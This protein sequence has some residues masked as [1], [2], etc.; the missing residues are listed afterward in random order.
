[1]PRNIP[2]GNGDLLMAYVG[3]DGHLHLLTRAGVSWRHADLGDAG[4]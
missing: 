3:A 4:L 2:V 1:M